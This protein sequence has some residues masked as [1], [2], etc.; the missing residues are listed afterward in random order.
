MLRILNQYLRKSNTMMDE[1]NISFHPS[2]KIVYEFKD[3]LI[4]REEEEKYDKKW[5]NWRSCVETNVN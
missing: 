3:I 4:I 1:I 5:I 2:L